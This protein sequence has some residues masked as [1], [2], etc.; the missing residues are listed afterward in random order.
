MFAGDLQQR[1]RGTHSALDIPGAQVDETRTDS[2]GDVT[3]ISLAQ[4]ISRSQ[5]K[6]NTHLPGSLG[7]ELVRETLVVAAVLIENEKCHATSPS[8]LKQSP[9]ETM[10]P[11]S[12]L[13][14]GR[15]LANNQ[16]GSIQPTHAQNKKH[17]Q[18]VKLSHGLD[19][20]LQVLLELSLRVNAR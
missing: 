8:K 4:D 18:L 10:H 9:T 19:G 12:V 20:S 2:P 17:E 7:M 11:G 16:V 3:T 13:R 14:S 1:T 15:H 6:A 5:S